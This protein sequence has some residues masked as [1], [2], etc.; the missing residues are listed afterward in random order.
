MPSKV[1]NRIA[2]AGLIAALHVPLIYYV[3][4]L[5]ASMAPGSDLGDL[6]AMSSL[7]LVSLFV[8]PY[9]ALRVAGIRWNP[10]RARVSEPYVD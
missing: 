8:L 5:R 2:V 3:A 7:I 9:I 1:L 10:T 6:S 4:T